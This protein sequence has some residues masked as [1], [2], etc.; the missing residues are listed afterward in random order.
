MPLPI[1]NQ[2][3]AKLNQ[4][5]FDKVNELDN[6]T[7]ITGEASFI[8]DKTVQVV[9]ADDT[10]KITADHIHINT[11]AYNW[12][13]PI[14]GLKDSKFAHDSTS[15]MQLT[16]LPKQLVIIGGGIYWVGICLYLCWVW[17]C[18]HDFR[19]CRYFFLPKKKMLTFAKIC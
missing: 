11:G 13:P 1:K 6:A 14:D 16:Q 17:Q 9:T 19:N 15:I 2:L 5:N 3:I 10:L 8:D 18:G 4:A 7:V 12:Q